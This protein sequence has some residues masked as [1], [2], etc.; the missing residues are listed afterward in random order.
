[1]WNLKIPNSQKQTGMVVTLGLWGR[2][3]KGDVS[4]SINFQL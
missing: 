4:H 1:M 3:G 2:G